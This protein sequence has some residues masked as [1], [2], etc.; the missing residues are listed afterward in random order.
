VTGASADLVEDA[1]AF[2]ARRAELAEVPSPRVPALL[3]RRPADRSAR[4]NLR[5][6]LLS[7]LV[8]D[9]QDD[10]D[11]QDD[12]AACVD[13]EVA[14]MPLVVT[15]SRIAPQKDLSVLIQAASRMRQT[16]TWVVLGDGDPRLL[17]QLRAEVRALG[18]PVYFL[19][20][21][22]DPGPWLRAAE[23]FVLPSRWEARA[24]VVQEAM[25]AGTPVVVSDVG[26]LHDLVA[27]TGLLVIPGDADAIAEAT[28]R[29]LAD[30][31]LREELAARGREVAAALPDGHEMAARWLTWYSPTP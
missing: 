24:L 23:V 10:Q 20:R 8:P 18:A 29:V 27:G 15:V 12:P 1:V 17:A 19:G 28:D 2:G 7:S 4:D 30:P 3:A 5:R 11:D 21:C 22:P 13:R 25:A 31:D 26:G 9:D 6:S 14:E 16:C